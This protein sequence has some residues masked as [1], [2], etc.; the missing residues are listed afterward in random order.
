VVLSRFVGFLP[1]YLYGIALAVV[2]AAE[3]DDETEYREVV[4]TSAVLG[5]IAFAAWFGLG[6]VRVAAF[7]ALVFGLLPIH[8]MPGKVLFSRRRWLWLVIWGIAVLAFFHVLINP[9]S[10]YLVDN[11]LVPTVTTYA[12]LG[13]FTL[14]SIGL[15]AWFRRSDRVGA[16]PGH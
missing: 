13:L 6:A 15:W 11:A 1:G 14:V 2:F 8:G 4:V 7:E 9:R 10:G 5:V 16:L 12:L 3:V